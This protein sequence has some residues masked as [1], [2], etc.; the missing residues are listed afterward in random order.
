MQYLKQLRT[1]LL[2]GIVQGQ[3]QQVILST[4]TDGNHELSYQGESVDFDAGTGFSVSLENDL[5]KEESLKIGLG[6]EYMFKRDLKDN[7][8]EIKF[9]NIVYGTIKILL[10]S[11][12][13]PIYAK[14]KVGYSTLKGDDDYE[15]DT[16]F[17]VI[18]KGGMLYGFGGEV[19][20]NQSNF[21]E[22]MFLNYK[23]G[24]FVNNVDLDI[25]HTHLNVG[26]G[27]TF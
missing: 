9:E 5:I 1:I 7:M 24:A 2:I 17:P 26:V 10:S 18:Y 8:G 23:S 12:T 19:Y 22:L 13:N 15:G 21:V 20:L 3:S 25:K 11:K 6:I 16:L 27:F 4:N 14:A